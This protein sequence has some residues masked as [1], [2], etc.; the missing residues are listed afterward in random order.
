MKNVYRLYLFS[1]VSYM[2]NTDCKAKDLD[3]KNPFYFSL[4]HKSSCNR[5]SHTGVFG[6]R[7]LL[8]MRNY[9]K[10]EFDHRLFM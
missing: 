5:G 7:A 3:L 2:F 8:K 9:P 1:I 6:R 10:I 4:S